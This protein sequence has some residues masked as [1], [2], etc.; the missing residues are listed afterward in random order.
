VVGRMCK[1]TFVRVGRCPGKGNKRHEGEWRH[2][3]EIT[4]KDK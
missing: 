2:V 1:K 4:L 3:V